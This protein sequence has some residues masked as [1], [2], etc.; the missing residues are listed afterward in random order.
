MS[1]VLTGTDQKYSWQ[2]KVFL[3]PS[4]KRTPIKVNTKIWIQSHKLEDVERIDMR[5]V[6]GLANN[7]PN[8]WR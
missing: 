7:S 4:N 8:N 3:N 1:N 6:A 2:A 5:E